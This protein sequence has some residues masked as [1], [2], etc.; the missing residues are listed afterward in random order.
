MKTFKNISF[1]LIAALFVLLALPTNG[2]AQVVD[3]MYLNA[4]WQVNIPLGNDFASGA[5]GW[6][7]NFEGGYYATPQLGIGLFVAYSTNNER[8][9]K[10]SLMLEDG[11]TITA[12]QQHS[13]FQ[14]PFGAA[15]RYRFM[16]EN[17][18]IPY[19]GLKLGANYAQMSTYMNT[20]KVYDNTWGFYMSPEIGANMFLTAD[21]KF[22]IHVAA[23]YSYGSNDGR[24]LTYN[25]NSLNNFG[26][27]LG[28]CF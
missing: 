1:K 22:G 26:I 11:S 3:K 15:L 9:G 6:G 4:D 13:V 28:V 21:K 14:L 25:I 19:V 10:E 5:S 23:Y 16:P 7:A 8:I 12:E 17:Q 24:V 20:F 2:Q 18:F 27:R